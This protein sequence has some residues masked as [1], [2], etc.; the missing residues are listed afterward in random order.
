MILITG[1]F[2]IFYLHSQ[3]INF[4]KETIKNGGMLITVLASN[5][6]LG[7][8]AEDKNQ[9]SESLKTA[10]NV[11]GIVGACAYNLEGE[12]LHR[13]TRTYWD[14]TGICLKEKSI[15]GDFFKSLGIT[16][17]VTHLENKKTVEF[18]S[19]VR[20]KPDSYSE[21]S[22]YFK[23]ESVPSQP[24]MGHL[25]GFVGVIFDKSILQQ[26]IRDMLIRHILLLAVFLAGACVLAYYIIQAV[27][28]PL[29]ELIARIKAHDLKV[30]AKDDL[31]I[32][33]DTFDGIVDTLG[34]SFETIS[35]LKTGLEK[36]VDELEREI[37]VR[38]KTETALLESENKFRSISD[39]IAD[40]VAIIQDGK[41]KWIN[42]SFAKIFGYSFLD[43]IGKGPEILFQPAEQKHT[44]SRIQEWKLITPSDSRYQTEA[45][46]K[47]GTILTLDIKASGLF[48]EGKPATEVI[49]RNITEK[50]QA[51]LE[52]N[53]LEIKALSQSKLAAIGEIATGVAHEMNQPLTYIKIVYQSALLDLEND[54]RDLK[55]MKSKF[56]E[57]LR[58][59]E[60]ITAVTEHLRSFGRKD[61]SSYSPMI[62]TVAFN[63]T[64]ILMGEKLRLLNMDIIR[65]FED[66][67]PKINGNKIQ[68]E[69][70]FINLLQ[71]SI[72]A[73]EKD[74]GGSIRV[75]IKRNGAFLETTFSDTGPGILEDIRHKIFEP[76]FTSK[77]PEG[78]TGLGL[79]IV[80]NIIKEH[81]GTITYREEPEWG[82]TFVISLPI[83]QS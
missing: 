2:N 49:V 39:G 52:K 55:A 14:K 28:K 26:S 65:E 54:K 19:P 80:E 81:N 79:A 4:E 43:I 83:I 31:D 56:K 67:L 48:F 32:L 10:V 68:L 59:V 53:E 24:E 63:N 27:T 72:D 60:R 73:M 42:N 35:E 62:M 1:T 45:Y 44:M 70:V 15:S 13:E 58:Q 47:D 22:F 66:D 33:A 30:E 11:K 78:G 69:Q 41:F 20:T 37:N 3:R 77:G 34:E 23:E 50:V 9:I 6:R 21:E 64:M 40:G 36:K 25:I 46:R 57:A 16:S 17:K 8:F 38:K 5:S 12:L 51:E 75:S 74:N 76:F 7:I 71:N 61:M 18:W 82:A 29:N